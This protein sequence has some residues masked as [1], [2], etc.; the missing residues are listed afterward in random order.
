MTNAGLEPS[1]RMSAIKHGGEAMRLAVVVQGKWILDAET[2]PLADKVRMAA[3]DLGR[4]L[5][6]LR[7]DQGQHW[8]AAGPFEAAAKYLSQ[9]DRSEVAEALQHANLAYLEVAE[10]RPTSGG[11]SIGQ[12]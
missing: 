3:N 9:I 8:D 10:H 11:G 1:R 12:Y 4:G 5:A 2:R 7:D 6:I